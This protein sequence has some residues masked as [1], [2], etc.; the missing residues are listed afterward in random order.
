M[1]RFVFDRRKRLIATIAISFTFFVAELTAGFYTHS[2]ALVA[3]AFHYLSDLLSFVVAL[4]ALHVSEGSTPPPTGYTFGWHRAVLLGAFFNGI[5]LLALG[6]SILVQAIERFV[7]I[8]P[9]DN[10]QLVLIIGCVGFALNVLSLL[11][12]HEHDHGNNERND[13]A[14]NVSEEAIESEAPA[15]SSA[16]Q[17]SDLNATQTLTS[18]MG[19]EF[20]MADSKH[21]HRDRG[22]FDV[23]LGILGLKNRDLGMLGAVAHVI[24]DLFGNVAVIVSAAVIWARTGEKRYYVDP[25]ISV[26]IAFLIF[27]TAIPLSKKTGRIMMQAAPEG[28][29]TLKIKRDIEMIPGIVAIHEFHIW[30]LDQKKTQASMHA[31]L[32]ESFTNNSEKWVATSK[33]IREVL[34]EYGIHMSILQPEYTSIRQVDYTAGD[35]ESPP[36]RIKENQSCEMLCHDPCR[37]EKC[38]Q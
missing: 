15:R 13:Q 30:Q 11:V 8:S 32:D 23:L 10:P 7:H 16:R 19:H 38:C 33:T 31:V 34:H 5:L 14:C 21:I 1:G 9:I 36:V 18:H 27:L 37:A 26:C 29:D 35:T 2:L 25:A 28:M 22:V 6:I 17:S 4:A 20:E 3:D 24:S 12:L